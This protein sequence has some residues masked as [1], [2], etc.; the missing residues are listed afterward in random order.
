MAVTR[1]TFGVSAET[2]WTKRENIP[3]RRAH[4]TDPK[5]RLITVLIL[6]HTVAG[7]WNPGITRWR[8]IV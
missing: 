2:V 7:K 8:L 3:A 6:K 1:R 4:L 5:A